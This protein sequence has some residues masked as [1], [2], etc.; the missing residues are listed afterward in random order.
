MAKFVGRRL[1]SADTKQVNHYFKTKIA[2]K[3]VDLRFICYYE[4]TFILVVNGVPFEKLKELEND[5]TDS[6]FEIDEEQK[7][8]IDDGSLMGVVRL[9][10]REFNARI[11]RMFFFSSA[12]EKIA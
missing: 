9:N 2:G 1:D 12:R 6:S 10:H 4:G 5:K 7:T 11:D 3:T 8:I